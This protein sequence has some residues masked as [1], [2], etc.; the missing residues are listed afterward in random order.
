MLWWLGWRNTSLTPQ[1][2]RAESKGRWFLAL[3]GKPFDFQIC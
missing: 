3:S 1:N 2:Q